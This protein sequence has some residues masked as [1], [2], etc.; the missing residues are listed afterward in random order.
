MIKTIT[1]DFG[2][3]VAFF[4]HRL[5]SKRL[6]AHTDLPAADLHAFLFGGR[7]EDDY[8]AGRISTAEF[9]GRAREG[10]RLRCTDEQ[11]HA[12][13]ADIFW[14]N[15]DVCALIPRLAARYRLLLLSNTNDLHAARF[16]PQ[17]ADTLRHFA[18]LVLSHEVG[19][20][21]PGPE[22]FGHALRL[23]GCASEECVFIDDL[24]ANVAGA[25]AVGW[26]GVLYTDHADLTAG[27]MNL[28]VTV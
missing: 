3:V 24:P 7:L 26:Q 27:L 18:G 17:F 13:Y 16:R 2:N 21:K 12:A 5:A 10:C 19:A 25:R 20:R 6:A 8:E 15:T 4:D 14:A 11:F 22:I 23:A 9:V 28:G 1:F